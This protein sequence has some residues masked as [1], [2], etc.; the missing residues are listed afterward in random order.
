MSTKDRNSTFSVV[1]GDDKLSSPSP[2]ERPGVGR[3]FLGIHFECCSLYSRIYKNQAG[4]AYEGQCPQCC[5][6]LKVS[7][8]SGG[9][10]KRFFRAR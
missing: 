2:V 8:G 7:I 3:A 9:T 1:V 6:K 10:G 4:T 5:A